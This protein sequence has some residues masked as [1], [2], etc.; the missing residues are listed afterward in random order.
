MI[1]FG[2]KLPIHLAINLYTMLK[3]VRFSSDTK[4]D[5][6]HERNL[7]SKMLL[8]FLKTKSK[9]PVF[10]WNLI[11]YILRKKELI[12]LESAKKKKKQFRN[13]YEIQQYLKKIK[14]KRESF[15][16]YSERINMSKEDYRIVIMS[17]KDYF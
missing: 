9:H 7:G 5:E 6:Q 14:K 17:D 4:F 1:T 16:R 12:N 10:T 8:L 3:V 13:N 2:D 15:I 11:R